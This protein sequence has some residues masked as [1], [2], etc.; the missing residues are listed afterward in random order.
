[1]YIKGRD[2]SDTLHLSC[3]LGFC[4]LNC[5]LYWS[6]VSYHTTS[7]QTFASYTHSQHHVV[8]LNGQV[9]QDSLS[10]LPLNNNE[11]RHCYPPRRL[12]CSGQRPGHL[13]SP[14][15]SSSQRAATGDMMSDLQLTLASQ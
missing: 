8:N 9:Q 1:M 6:L 14:L 15:S 11:G 2:L 3:L 13:V 5:T 4:H 10:H 12:G 7:E